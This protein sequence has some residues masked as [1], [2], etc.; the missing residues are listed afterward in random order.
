MGRYMGLDLGSKTLG[1]ALSDPLHIIASS[2]DT[3]RFDEDDYETALELLLPL[4]KEN[5]VEKIVLGLPK[6][7]N[8]DLGPRAQISI[9]FKDMINEKSDVEVVL[10]DERNTTK[11]MNNMLISDF[12]LSRKKRKKIIDKMAAVNILQTY[13]D[14]N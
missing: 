2:L 12:D 1:I 14:R 7:M 5:D 11:I 9:D 4:I 3:L 6:L 13:L 10:W 8:N